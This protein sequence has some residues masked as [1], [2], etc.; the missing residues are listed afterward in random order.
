MLG[1]NAS[2]A[3]VYQTASTV[4]NG[5]TTHTLTLSTNTLTSTVNGV[6]ATS[7]AVSG[8]NNTSS[9]N[10][11]STTVNGVAGTTVP[12]IN[13][14]TNTLTQAGGLVTTVNGVA[15]TTSFASGTINKI[16]GFSSTGVPV[17]Q[18]PGALADSVQDY[19]WRKAGN[20]N[21]SAPSDTVN[22][23]YHIGGNVGIG[24]S[25][26]TAQLDVNGTARIR[27]L[28][29]SA[30]T[31]S[32]V[33]ADSS[34]NLRKRTIN[35]LINNSGASNNFWNI[36]GN[37]GT[38]YATNFLGTTDNVSTRFR[39]NNIQRM[40]IDSI[41]SVGIGST[42]FDPIDRERLLVDYGN[43]TS[44]TVA[45]FEGSVDDYFQI[46]LQNKSGT[47]NASTDFVA[48]ANDGTDSTY[49]VDMGINSSNYAFAIDNWGQAHDAY[50]YSYSKNLYIGTQAASSDVIFL[51][52][53][54]R[55][56]TNAALRIRGN[57]GNIVVGKGDASATPLGNILRGPNGYGTNIIGGNL[58]IQGG[59]STGSATAGTLYL[60]GGTVSGITP[61]STVNN[62]PII[63]NTSNIERMR[64]DSVGN[65]GIGT[66]KSCL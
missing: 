6:V 64:I 18:S 33:T 3:P 31:D 24:T 45:S 52:G 7:S 62:A 53:G 65:I 36:A 2:G 54:G 38:N 17:Y 13:T 41:G 49:Y 37:A 30:S 22:N 23:I 66:N 8:V 40:I 35:D 63:M 43:T 27:A 32:V 48:T 29:S 1:Y 9:A 47:G 58:T 19:D 60:I 57:T 61:G 42:A 46:N 21:P 34:G 14:N 28:G 39:T 12:I 59:S 56:V 20:L 16:L 51:V 15:A 26:S 44:N 10:T 55:A 11:L 25:S 4:L 50:L 5:A